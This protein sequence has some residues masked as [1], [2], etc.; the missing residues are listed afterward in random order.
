MLTLGLI[1]AIAAT[2]CPAAATAQRLVPPG[3]SGVNQYTE[4]F[5]TAGGDA[6][7]GDGGKRSPKKVLGANNARRLEEAGPEGRAAAALAAATAPASRAVATGHGGS[8]GKQAGGGGNGRPAA[9]GVSGSSGLG[10]VIGQATGASSSGQLGILLPLAIV[11]AAIGSLAF[12]W[13]RRR[14]A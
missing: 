3:N 8:G 6:V 12:L 2:L 1:G 7:A 13:R 9:G 14:A 4:T 5:P 10:E 11:A